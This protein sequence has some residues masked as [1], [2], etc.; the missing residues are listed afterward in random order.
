[1]YVPNTR[2]SKMLF[3]PPFLLA[4]YEYIHLGSNQALRHLLCFS[5]RCKDLI[6]AYPGSK[7]NLVNDW[8]N[9]IAYWEESEQSKALANKCGS[10]QKQLGGLRW[11]TQYNPKKT[12]QFLPSFKLE[13]SAP[14]T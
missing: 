7:K 8:E 10:F 13:D 11:W 12:L 3:I 6:K 9:I 5:P 14:S 4:F 1:M 2:G